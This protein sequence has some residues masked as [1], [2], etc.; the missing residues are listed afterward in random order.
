MV[1]KYLWNILIGFDQFANTIFAGDPDMTLSGNM[2][3][4]VKEGRCVLCKPICKAIAFAFRDPNHCAEQDI[5]EQD[6]GKDQ[7]V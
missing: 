4:K 5:A 7:V 3:R 2:G 6:E 1:K